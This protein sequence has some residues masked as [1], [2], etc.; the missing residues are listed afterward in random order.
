MNRPLM[1]RV[2]RVAL[3]A[4]VWAS[5]LRAQ[6]A[7]P[8]DPAANDVVMRAMRDELARSVQQLR[9]D[10]LANPYFI[11]YR[12][13]EGLSRSASA[14]LGSLVRSD[15]GRGE[16]LLQVELRVGDYAFD[17]TNY[18]GA[19]FLPQAFVGLAGIPQDDD[20]QALRRQI[21]LATDRAYKQALEALSQKRAALEG[22]M[23]TDSIADFSREP[24]TNTTDDVPAPAAT[25]RKPLEALARELS[26]TFRQSEEIYNSTVGVSESWSRVRYVN[27]EGT[28]FTRSR[29][30]ASVNA[31]AS[32]Q[33]TDGTG[34]SM[35][36]SVQARSFDALPGKDSLLKGVRD[37]A[38]RITAQRH[39][40]LADAYDGPVL[41][42]GAAAA[43][44]FN[45][46]IAGKLVGSR[47]PVTNAALAAGFAAMGQGGGNDWEDLIGSTVL[48]RWMSVVD[49]PTLQAV[50]DHPVDYY[51]V[52]DDGVTTR[53]TTV[54]DHGVLKTVLTGRTPV[55][56]V[57][58]STG[59]RFGAG[60]RP[61]HMI[62]TADSTLSDADVRAK[63]LALATAQGR[64]YGVIVRQLNVAGLSPTD[65]MFGVIGLPQRGGGAGP[66]ARGSRVVKLF[67]DG[68]EEPMR[69]AEIFGLT[70]NSFKEIAAVSRSRTVHDLP[71][72]SGGNVF[73]GGAGN[74]PVTYQT[75]S[76]LFPN[77]TIRK[78]R[79]TT[80]SLPVV[81]P[82]R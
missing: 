45:S 13:T 63:L 44:L 3:L 67:A 42:E 62:V 79:G 14:R 35:S 65:E 58:H 24:A 4:G 77:V 51:K 26:A 64:A 28:S 48:P 30:R 33:A 41:F 8:G 31:S 2:A 47:R 54:V 5:A 34:Q 15:E 18:F 25:D 56:G 69:G 32:T 9:L 12:V 17:N 52:D 46:M 71:F 57:D 70:A 78:P 43:E 29:V 40:P 20:Y 60:A 73:T 80:P 22:R 81:G 49:D 68:H 6:S 21:W 7:K 72:A 53:P 19:G 59:N 36:Y 10:T 66:V 55:M 16:R 50:G 27:S 75:S 37:L 82:P 39:V 76:F 1:R 74:G 38:S 11:A 61:L 23:R